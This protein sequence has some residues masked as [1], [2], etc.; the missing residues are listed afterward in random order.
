[1][2]PFWQNSWKFRFNNKFQL[3]INLE[4]PIEYS[5]TKSFVV[6]FE[7]FGLEL[8]QRNFGMESVIGDSIIKSL[9][10]FFVK[11]IGVIMIGC[12]FIQLVGMMLEGQKGFIHTHET[13]FAIGIGFKHLNFSIK[14]GIIHSIILFSF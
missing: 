1:M 9:V 10:K 11:G 13:I 6:G 14:G 4:Y 12:Y 2:I 5:T 7:H 8:V 3:G